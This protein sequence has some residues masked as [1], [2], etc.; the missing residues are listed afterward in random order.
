MK[1]SFY[2]KVKKLPFHKGFFLFK[3]RVKE[4]GNKLIIKA[5]LLIT[6]FLNHLLRDKYPS[7]DSKLDVNKP[8]HLLI[9]FPSLLFGHFYS[10]YKNREEKLRV[11]FFNF[12]DSVSNTRIVY[13]IVY[14]SRGLIFTLAL[15]AA[16]SFIPYFY[17]FNY[18]VLIDQNLI[19]SLLIAYVGGTTAIL[20]IIFA[21]YSVGFQTT[22]ERFSSNV[23]E[24]LNS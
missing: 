18:P 11:W 7:I 14:H 19:N 4:V 9:K 12:F 6:N 24:Y 10:R 16:I 20:G 5:K 13:E 8:P 22:T 23:T 3:G 15:L 17:F 2:K 1:N 21:L